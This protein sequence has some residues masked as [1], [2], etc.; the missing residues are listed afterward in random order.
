MYELIK[1]GEWLGKSKY[2]DYAERKYGG[3]DSQS[4]RFGPFSQLL[5]QAGEHGGYILGR[6][7]S[8]E[9]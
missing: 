6:F 3:G 4:P 7:L 1:S 9:V 5:R 2:L 8:E